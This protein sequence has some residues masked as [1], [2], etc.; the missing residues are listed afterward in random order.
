MQTERGTTERTIVEIQRDRA[1]AAKALA[2]FDVELKEAMA[3]RE[4]RLLADFDAGELDRTVLAGR[5]GLT[6]QGVGSML[7]RNGR[8]TWAA[9]TPVSHLPADVQ[10]EIAKLRRS[11]VPKEAA[12][13]IATELAGSI[14]AHRGDSLEAVS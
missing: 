6:L 3:K 14:A 9:R 13:A 1:D 5:Y 4:A 8:R 10:R 2:E 11:G 7:H 12:R